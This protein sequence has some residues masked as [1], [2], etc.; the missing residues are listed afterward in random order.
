VARAFLTAGLV[1][2]IHLHLFPVLLGEGLPL[3]PAA[4]PQH[5]LERIEARTYADGTL[6][7]RYRRIS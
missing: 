1:D 6:G 4:F 7:L 2:Q 3:F 5:N